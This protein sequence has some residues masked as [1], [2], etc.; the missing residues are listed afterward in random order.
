MSEGG[1]CSM[2]GTTRKPHMMRFSLSTEL[3][4]APRGSLVRGV[5]S[6]GEPGTEISS[7]PSKSKPYSI[8]RKFLSVD[9]W[10][11]WW[12]TSKSAQRRFTCRRDSDTTFEQ[13]WGSLG[14]SIVLLQN[15]HLCEHNCMTCIRKVATGAEAMPGPLESPR[16][17]EALVSESVEP[18]SPHTPIATRAST[19]PSRVRPSFTHNRL[20][21]QIRTSNIQSSDNAPAWQML[22]CWFQSW[23]SHSFWF[24]CDL[25]SSVNKSQLWLVNS[26]FDSF[27]IPRKIFRNQKQ[28]LAS[29]RNTYLHPWV[30]PLQSSFGLPE[31]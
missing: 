19:L 15:D 14:T 1:G 16:R 31:F 20:R 10:M 30:D 3:Q 7:L 22:L 11:R 13:Q 21:T 29:K 27:R 4:V 12:H 9:K 24:W 25:D 8:D 17:D 2:D 28:Y 23:P 18:D 26:F 5:S 6:P